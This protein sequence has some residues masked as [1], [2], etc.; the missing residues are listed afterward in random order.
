M[1]WRE[2]LLDGRLQGNTDCHKT[3]WIIARTSLLAFL[4]SSRHGGVSLTPCSNVFLWILACLF[5]GRVMLITTGQLFP[6]HKLT[7]FLLFFQCFLLATRL[8]IHCPMRSFRSYERLFFLLRWPWSKDARLQRTWRCF[9]SIQGH[10]KSLLF[11]SCKVVGRFRSWIQNWSL[12]TSQRWFVG[13]SVFWPLAAKLVVLLWQAKIRGRPWRCWRFIWWGPK[14]RLQPR[15]RLSHPRRELTL[16]CQFMR[17][18]LP[19]TVILLR[20]LLMD[21]KLFSVNHVSALDPE[22]RGL[23]KRLFR[24]QLVYENDKQSRD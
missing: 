13:E 6:Y 10:A 11:L 22:A 2:I 4:L 9:A 3:F 8:L 19:R 24:P 17:G 18:L 7:F 20:P 5:T 21:Q 15:P 23:A 12:T 16:R 14:G 1:L